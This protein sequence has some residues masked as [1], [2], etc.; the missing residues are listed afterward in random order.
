MSALRAHV[1]HSNI[2]KTEKKMVLFDFGNRIAA[3]TQLLNEFLSGFVLFLALLRSAEAAGALLVHFRTRSHTNTRKWTESR[4][5]N[6]NKNSIFSHYFYISIDFTI[7]GHEEELARANTCEHAVDVLVAGMS[8]SHHRKKKQPYLEDGQVHIVLRLGL[9]S[10]LRVTGRVDNAVHVKI[11]RVVFFAVR[12]WQRRVDR[13]F[14]PIRRLNK[15]PH[16]EQYCK[17]HSTVCKELTCRCASTTLTTVLG[18]FC[19][20]H[21]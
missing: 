5:P 6:D 12:V 18:Y 21:R 7:N 3:G 2:D 14:T 17:K 11:Q 4:G 9:G 16:S 10:M 1:T 19:E 20:S 15:Y 8:V 13:H